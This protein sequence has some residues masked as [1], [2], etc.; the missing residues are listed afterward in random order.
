MPLS[1]R[2]FRR[3]TSSR[4]I[5]SACTLLFAGGAISAAAA[6]GATIAFFV[7]LGLSGL[8]LFNLVGV[9]ADRYTLDETGIEQRNALLCRLGVRA[10]RV[11]WE[12]IVS[13][14]E[15]FPP[16]R[17][18]RSGAPTAVFLTRRDGGRLVLDSLERFDDLVATLR[19]LSRPDGSPPVRGDA[20]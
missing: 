14:R 16:R 17:D 7:L 9:W 4:V 3:S 18:R 6:T 20:P 19:R 8:S 15:V 1:R 11:A 13:V 5:G 12:E 10:R 2:T